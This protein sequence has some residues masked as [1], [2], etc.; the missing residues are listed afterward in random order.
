MKTC[1][2]CNVSKERT[3]FYA[4]PRMADGLLG[5]C[6]ECAKHDV[7]ARYRAVRPERVAY[8][9]K[10]QATPERRRQHAETARRRKIREPIKAFAWDAVKRAI[11]SGSLV[12]QP[13]ESCGTTQR[14]QAHHDDYNKPLAVRWLCFR[15]HREWHGQTVSEDQF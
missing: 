8:E 6:K 2:K 7:A 3:E 1:F 14:V 9:R 11:R 4:H 5:K 13:C 12:R 15:H 10:R